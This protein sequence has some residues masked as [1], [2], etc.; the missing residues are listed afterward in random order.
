MMNMFIN[1]VNHVMPLLVLGLG[2]FGNVAA[3]LVL[4]KGKLKKLGPVLMYKLLFIWETFYI[5]Q[6]LQP[7][8][9]YAFNL[10]VTTLS[11]F[12]CKLF[13]YFN[14]QGD[15]ISPFLLVYISFEKYISIA[16]PSKRSYFIS[17]RNQI[18]YFNFIFWYSSLYNILVPF[19]FGLI[20]IKETASNVTN[21]SSLECFKRDLELAVDITDTLN[22][23]I[24]PSILMVFFSFLL[25]KAIFKSRARTR[26]SIISIRE[27]RRNKRDFKLAVSCFSMNFIFILLNTPESVSEFYQ[28]QVFYQDVFHKT[29]LYLFYL[30]YGVNFY[31]IFL[32]NS[33][34]RKEFYR[35]FGKKFLFF[36]KINTNQSFSINTT[37]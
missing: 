8:F 23:E 15:T 2:L 10:N 14:Y 33:L 5:I 21:S 9:H 24:I 17:R 6:I 22:R 28:E 31:V 12:A 7:Y 37:E 36:S 30:C 19:S 1:F 34:V 27:Q 20:L 29:S 35:I 32:C 16:N 4:F 13:Y 11:S 25:I 18:I 3:L 26:N